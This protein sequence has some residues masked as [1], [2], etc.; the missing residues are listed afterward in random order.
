MV[1][2]NAA[3]L[4]VLLAMKIWSM[5]LPRWLNLALWTIVARTRTAGYGAGAV[6]AGR[7]C[8][9]G[10]LLVGNGVGRV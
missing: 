2:S 3:I 7:V 6:G 9:R 4:T 8:G 5:V 10:L 1:V